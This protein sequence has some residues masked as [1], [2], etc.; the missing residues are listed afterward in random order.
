MLTTILKLSIVR[1]IAAEVARLQNSALEVIGAAAT[2][3]GSAY[4]ELIVAIRSR[5]GGSE[6]VIVTVDRSGGESA[7]R[8]AIARR[9]REQ[10]HRRG[11][12]T[13]SDHAR[14]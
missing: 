8:R 5:S 12:C 6:R 14:A 4:I 7:L 13:D 1:D 9:L 3:G 11:L 2:S 10:L